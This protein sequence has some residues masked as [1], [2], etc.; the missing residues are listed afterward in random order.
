MIDHRD[1]YLNGK[2]IFPD[3]IPK[4]LS[5]KDLVDNY[6]NGYNAARVQEIC[7]LVSEKMSSQDVCVGFSLSGALTPAGLGSSCIVPMIRSGIIDYIV[8]TGA[9]LYHDLHHSLDLPLSQG[10]PFVNDNEL[11]E[12]DIIRIYDI[13]MDYEVLAATDNWLMRTFSRPEFQKRMGTRELH[14]LLGKFADEIEQERGTVGKSFIAEAYRYDVPIF[15]SSPGDSTLGLDIA[16]LNLVGKEIYIDPSIDV[17]ETTALVLDAKHSG[18]SGVV[19]WGG[20]S[21]K[22]FILQPEPALQEVLGF[23]IKGHDYFVQ[24][25]DAR[26][27]T[28]G[29][30]GAT[31][32]EA[33]SWAKIDPDTVNQSV[34]CYSD[35]TIVMPLLTAYL[36]SCGV[37]RDPKR[38]NKKFPKIVDQLRK[39]F[40][41]QKDLILGKR[42]VLDTIQFLKRSKDKD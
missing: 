31:P 42:S 29:L 37:R 21:P 34:V 12:K 5:I 7:H 30:S 9:N 18:K 25:T 15:T 27:D 11:F 40:L 24:V 28:G 4:G 16:A 39:K 32:N 10:T 35:T 20:G 19:V 41:E 2:R 38:L 6:F 17:N 14:Y 23:D 36:E 3:P 13:F 26:P 33:V 1:K 8:T 22:N